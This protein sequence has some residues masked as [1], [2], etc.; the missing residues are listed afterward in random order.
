MDGSAKGCRANQGLAT[1]GK[2]CSLSSDS[3]VSWMGGWALWPQ[4][5]DA[6]TLSPKRTVSRYVFSLV[7][8]YIAG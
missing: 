2:E 4:A 7:S 8:L 5:F 3:V 1:H 6:L